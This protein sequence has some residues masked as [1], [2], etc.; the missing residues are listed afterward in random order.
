MSE[1]IFL[2]KWEDSLRNAE[3]DPFTEEEIAFMM[4]AAVHYGRDGEKTDFEKVF[5]RK[6]LNR[7]FNSYYVQIDSI[8]D[9]K[10]KQGENNVAQGNQSYDNDAIKELAMQG[11]TQKEI[12]RKLGYDEKKSRSLSSNKGYRAGIEIFKQLPPQQQNE[13]KSKKK[14]EIVSSDSKKSE[15]VRNESEINTSDKKEE[16]RNLS[17]NVRTDSEKVRNESEVVSLFNF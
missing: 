11:Y 3:I 6:D 8:K 10:N 15:K 16:V 1:I 12:C 14:L 4:Y 9:F 13:L 2:K 7:V 5:N 17:E